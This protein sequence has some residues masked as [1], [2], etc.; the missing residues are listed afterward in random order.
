MWPLWLPLT[1]TFD[2]LCQLFFSLSELVSHLSFHFPTKKKKNNT[3][4]YALELVLL[5]YLLGL[6]QILQAFSQTCERNR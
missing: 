4:S 1:L 6:D 5:V 3:D 2:K